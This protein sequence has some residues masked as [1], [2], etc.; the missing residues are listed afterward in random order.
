[1]DALEAAARRELVAVLM[2]RAPASA[3][4]LFWPL[5]HGE[6]RA[7]LPA[8]GEFVDLLRARGSAPSVERVSIDA[9]SFASRDALEGFVRQQLW[10]DPA[11][12]KQARLR[13]SIDEL[14]VPDG[15]GWTIRG[16]GSVSVGIVNWAAPTEP[17]IAMPGPAS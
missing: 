14:A 8:L 7:P 9:R 11:G 1:V 17:G 2:D 6:I 4:D 10:I 5:V 16:R 12:A 3:A 15:D 13:E